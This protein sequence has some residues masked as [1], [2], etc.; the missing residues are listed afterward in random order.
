M[1]KNLAHFKPSIANPSFTTMVLTA[2]HIIR[3]EVWDTLNLV[4]KFEWFIKKGGTP[5]Q[6]ELSVTKGNEPR[7]VYSLLVIATYFATLKK[8]D[9][10]IELHELWG[11]SIADHKNAIAEMLELPD[12]KQASLSNEEIEIAL[13]FIIE[14]WV[15]SNMR[16]WSNKTDG[17]LFGASTIQGWIDGAN[18]SKNRLV[19]INRR[20]VKMSN[21]EFNRRLDVCDAG[22]QVLK[23]LLHQVEDSNF[24]ID[25]E[26]DRAKHA[27]ER[28][29]TKLDQEGPSAEVMKLH[30]ATVEILTEQ[31][32]KIISLRQWFSQEE[33]ELAMRNI[34]AVTPASKK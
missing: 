15:K 28:F 17:N 13:S 8:S 7:F 16:F 29:L 2:P 6:I 27:I 10:G 34:A 14:D 31:N 21:R 30:K 20:A 24:H 4:S 26:Q 18:K 11:M 19:F 12:E 23:D 9:R 32:E 5:T 25:F 3:E 1:K 22:I 33:A